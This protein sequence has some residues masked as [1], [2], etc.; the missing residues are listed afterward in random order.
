MR[1]LALVA[2][3]A[4]LA[5][6]VA[7]AHHSPVVFD[8]TKKVTIVGTVTEFKWSSPHSW[9]HIDVPDEQGRIGNWGV[10]M[11]PA[12][13]LARSG[14]RS[15]TIKPGDKVSI[16]VYPLRNNEKGGHYISITL[17]DGRTLGS[18]E[19]GVL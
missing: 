11:D 6:G 9:I 15:S 8:H 17:P 1:K 12:S 16:V 7:A 5:A 10:E 14:W 18:R 13:M 4:T 3:A 19:S 2:A